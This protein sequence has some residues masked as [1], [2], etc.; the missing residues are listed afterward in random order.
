MVLR[1]T[2]R[3]LAELVGLVWL[4]LEIVRLVRSRL[5]KSGR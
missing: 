4:A 3:D 2:R 1:R 5:E